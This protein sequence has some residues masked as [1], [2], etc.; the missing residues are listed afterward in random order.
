MTRIK[1]C[2]YCI[3]LRTGGLVIGVLSCTLSMFFFFIYLFNILQLQKNLSQSH[4]N[5]YQREF[6]K[7][8]LYVMLMT[9]PI[10]FITGIALIV[11]IM[12]RKSMLL[13]I[14]LAVQMLGVFRIIR[15]VFIFLS[16]SYSVDEQQTDIIEISIGFGK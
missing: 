1:V 8:I 12:K 9:Q 14:W 7:I 4:A 10:R 11:G 3:S 15:A 2:C 16:S 6:L 13:S 5:E